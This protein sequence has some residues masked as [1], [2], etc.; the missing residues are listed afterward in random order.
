MNRPTDP[1]PP[2]GD[3][4]LPILPYADQDIAPPPPS[5][6]RKVALSF[7]AVVVTFPALGCIALGFTIWI[8]A[9]TFGHP[10]GRAFAAGAVLLMMGLALL[11]LATLLLRLTQPRSTATA[12]LLKDPTSHSEG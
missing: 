7:A 3:G 2:A 5:R 4:S 8:S 1:I 9:M 11:R 12:A 10:G 6:V